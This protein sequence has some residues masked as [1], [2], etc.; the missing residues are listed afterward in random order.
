MSRKVI[1]N[2]TN[3]RLYCFPFFKKYKKS[4]KDYT[5]TPHAREPAYLA[6]PE[7]SLMSVCL[8]RIK[9]HS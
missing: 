3:F 5:L 9:V 6:V 8:F 7:L 2:K 1:S 4:L